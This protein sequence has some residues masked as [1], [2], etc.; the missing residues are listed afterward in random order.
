M[1]DAHQHQSRDPISSLSTSEDCVVQ[2]KKV[3]N[4]HSETQEEEREKNIRLT[5][6]KWGVTADSASLPQAVSRVPCV[7][8]RRQKFPADSELLKIVLAIER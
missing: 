1:A 8:L 5:S 2:T 7:F 6:L 4:R 3:D